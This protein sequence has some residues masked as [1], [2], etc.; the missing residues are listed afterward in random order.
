M[1]KTGGI[2]Y[3][4]LDVETTISEKG[5]PFHPDN[6]LCS[7]GI[8]DASGTTVYRIEH[9]DDPYGPALAEIKERI[10]RAKYLVGFNIKFDLHWIRRYCRDISF[11]LP[12]DCQLAAF[13]LS[14]QAGSYPAL[15]EVA[16]NLGCGTKLD[17][18]STEYW[19]RGI[20]TRE[21]PWDILEKYNAEDLEITDRVHQKQLEMLSPQQKVL[22]ALQG[23]DLLLLQEM[24]WNGLLYDFETAS[25][26][27]Q[28][29][30]QE[31][32]QIES[33]LAAIVKNPIV[34]FGS[35]D[36]LS[37]VLYGGV[38]YEDYRETY[39]RTL[40]D[41]TVK[42]KERWAK[43]PI[44]FR[45]MVKPLR[46]TETKPTRGI[47]DDELAAINRNRISEGRLPWVRHWSVSAETISRL[48]MGGKATRFVELLKRR[49]RIAKLNSTYYGGLIAK[50]DAKGW[51]DGI[52]HGQFN[53]CVARTGRLSSSE[54]NEQN[55]DDDIKQLFYSRFN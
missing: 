14:G 37:V 32:Q 15:D 4:V 10:E 39:T 28:K 1:S 30:Q 52:I 54:P 19:D 50:R 34:D 38:I 12:F 21:V 7:V 45:G 6:K 9:G 11:P 22:V 41:G 23:E 44:E 3:V 49:A 25:T 51:T 40:K 42:E 18:V 17:V 31:A 26:I 29:L 35:S 43:R 24:E 33:D 16:G 20:D 13:I 47:S 2:N 8:K 53:Q 55:F 5:H 27:G 36:H 46:G 48:R